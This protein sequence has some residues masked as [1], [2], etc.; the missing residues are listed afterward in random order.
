MKTTQ[1]TTHKQ[2]TDEW[3]ENR[4]GK[5]T[6]SKIANLLGIKGLGKTGETYAFEQ[7]VEKLYGRLEDSFLSYD[8]QRGIDL[9][10]LA[11]ALCLRYFHHYLQ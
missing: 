1:E 5:F 8:M 4:K 2:G 3:F 7:A 9:E 6:G 11:F 10:T